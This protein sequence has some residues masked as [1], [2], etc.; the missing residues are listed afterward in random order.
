MTANVKKK[1]R[2]MVV[3]DHFVVRMGLTGSINIEPDMTADSLKSPRRTGPRGL[4][5]SIGR[6]SS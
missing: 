3:D 2:V 5:R 4:S 6:I 1:I